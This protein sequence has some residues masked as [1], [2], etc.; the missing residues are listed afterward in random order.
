MVPLAEEIQPDAQEN[1]REPEEAI[2]PDHDLFSLQVACRRGGI[3][4]LVNED[5][6]RVRPDE[7]KGSAK[8]SLAGM[9]ARGVR[10][11]HMV[12]V[13][14]VKPVRADPFDRPILPHQAAEDGQQLFHRSGCLIASMGQQPVPPEGDTQAARNPSE[15]EAD[16]HGRP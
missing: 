8:V 1:A 15:E 7:P 4:V 2:D 9:V 11:R 16:R 3:F 6:A 14:V 10:V 13:R 5:P 12:G